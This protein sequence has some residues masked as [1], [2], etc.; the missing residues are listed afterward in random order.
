MTSP[1]QSRMR[2]VE[3]KGRRLGF[4]AAGR[5][6]EPVS[7]TDFMGEK[8]AFDGLA[9]SLKRKREQP[10][11]GHSASLSYLCQRREPSLSGGRFFVLDWAR[12]GRA[13]YARGLKKPITPGVKIHVAL[14]HSF[15]RSLRG[16]QGSAR[17]CAARRRPSRL[18]PCGILFAALAPRGATERCPGG[19]VPPPRRP[20][21][22]LPRYGRDEFRRV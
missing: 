12:A 11:S 13:T 14:A 2:R 4:N 22:D 16:K 6:S 17:P 19:G 5:A 3:R 21:R 18:C 15:R 1:A 8:A 20:N 10:F 7:P 9:N